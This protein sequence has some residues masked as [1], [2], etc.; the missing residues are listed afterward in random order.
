MQGH[1]IPKCGHSAILRVVRDEAAPKPF[2]L[3]P[4]VSAPRERMVP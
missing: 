4:W 1:R 3:R 2:L